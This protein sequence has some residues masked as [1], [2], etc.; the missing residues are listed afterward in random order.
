MWQDII[1]SV[2]YYGILLSIIIII[3][4]YL[5]E[6]FLMCIGSYPNRGS[7]NCVVCCTRGYWLVIQWLPLWG[8]QFLWYLGML[9]C[10]CLQENLF[11]K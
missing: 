1:F 9:L 6:D 4:F 3:N 2:V 5:V 10:Q 8:P 11:K 7:N